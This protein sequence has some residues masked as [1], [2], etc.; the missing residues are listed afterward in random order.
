MFGIIVLHAGKVEQ[1][2]FDKQ[3]GIVTKNRISIFC[4]KK[5]VE[6]T[7]DQIT[8]VRV[9]KRG[10]DSIQVMT[11]HYEVQIDFADIPSHTIIQS[12]NYEKA[13][14]QMAQIKEFLGLALNRNDLKYIDESTAR[15]G[16]R[17][18][19]YKE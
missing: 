18:N 5:T 4:K 12:L 8:N 9:F 17:A 6:W 7:I 16:R 3:I 19:R 2:I 10:H 11:I 15:Y 13:V 1:I 14:K